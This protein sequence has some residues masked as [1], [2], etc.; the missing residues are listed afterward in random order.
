MK[1]YI[2][3]E[4]IEIYAYHGVYE[5][6]TRVGNNFVI[7]LKLTIDISAA[8]DSDNLE[9]TLNYG[10]IYNIIKHEMSIPSKLLE[11]AGGRILRSLKGNF[12][13]IEQIELKLTKKNPPVG[14]P[15]E[16]ASIILID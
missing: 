14:G 10:E 2:L 6:E 16:S 8:V 7:N 12:P 11:H 5:H 3:L 15:L 9:D 13:K 1:S 4:N